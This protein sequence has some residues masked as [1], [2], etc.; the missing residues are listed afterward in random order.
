MKKIFFTFLFVIVFFEFAYCSSNKVLICGVCKNIEYAVQNTI[1]NIEA[2][3]NKF[4][5]YT[6]I[7]YENNSTDNTKHFLKQWSKQN[8]RVILIAEDLDQSLLKQNVKSFNRADGQPF[9]SELIAKA[10]NKVLDIAREPRFDEYEFI[11]MADLDF[12]TPWPIDEI[13]KTIQTEGDWDCVT[14]NG[15]MGDS[16]YDKYALRT[17][18]Y[19][20]GPELLGEFWWHQIVNTKIVYDGDKWVPVFSAFGGLGIYRKASILD[21]YYSGSVTEELMFDYQD[22]FTQSNKKNIYIW[23]YLKL[24]PES[25][26]GRG[27]LNIIFQMNSGCD[28]FPSCCEHVTLHAKMRLNGKGK[29]FI[30]PKMVV[31]Y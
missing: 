27:L 26:K 31:K 16:Y 6:V 15:I 22:I 12:S 8:S 4:E 11:V 30:N 1:C 21:S 9:R 24:Y 3:G 23:E 18:Q 28:L 29:I 5:D 17:F 20:F 14:A 2:L 7:I 13:V 10:R 19:P 25:Y